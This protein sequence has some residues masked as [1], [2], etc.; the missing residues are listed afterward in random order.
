MTTARLT[1]TTERYAPPA[2]GR[3]PKLDDPRRVEA[4]ENLAGDRR[5][6]L[7]EELNEAEHDVGQIIEEARRLA[8]QLTELPPEVQARLGRYLPANG[9]CVID[10]Q[11]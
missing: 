8:A 9:F 5:R 4:A 6:S 10:E 1:S 11:A 3:V 7:R 2:G